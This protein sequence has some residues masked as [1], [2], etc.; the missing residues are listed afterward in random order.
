VKRAEEIKAVEEQITAMKAEIA[1]LERGLV[2]LQSGEEQA[3]RRMEIG[4]KSVGDLLAGLSALL[5]LEYQYIG[6]PSL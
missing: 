2:R 6:Y 5:A 3:M 4:L 1:S